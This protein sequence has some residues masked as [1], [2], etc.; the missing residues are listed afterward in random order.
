M[1]YVRQGR[2]GGRSEDRLQE[3]FE[4]GHPVSESLEEG[5]LKHSVDR[6]SHACPLEDGGLKGMEESEGE[7]L[8]PTEGGAPDRGH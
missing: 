6:R 3:V 4:R 2:N 8:Q 7:G 1:G 5:T